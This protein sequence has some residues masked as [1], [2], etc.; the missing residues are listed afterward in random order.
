MSYIEYP[1][2]KVA[3][4]VRE[5]YKMAIVVPMGGLAPPNNG[6]DEN[7]AFPQF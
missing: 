7:F 5:Q 1:N 2:T 3:N 6:T 4:T